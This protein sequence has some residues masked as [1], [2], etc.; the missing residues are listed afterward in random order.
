MSVRIE[1]RCT[2]SETSIWRS[3]AV[4]MRTSDIL[5]ILLAASLPWS[6]SLVAIFAAIFLLSLIPTFDVKAFLLSVKRPASFFPIVLFGLAV[7]GTLWAADITWS[8][9]LNGMNPA[10]K[11]LAI[12]FL[13]YHF[14]KSDRGLWV[15]IA[16]LIS[17]TFVLALSWS[18]FIDLNVVLPS[19]KG[20]GVPVKN[21]IA[22]SQEFTLSAF[23]LLGASTYFFKADRKVLAVLFA[24][25]STLFLANMFFVAT[26]RTALICVPLLLLVFA[27]AHL[28]RRGVLLLVLV[29]FGGLALAWSTS[30]FLRGRVL[31][32]ASEYHRYHDENAV[33]STGQRLE[34]WRKSLKFIQAAP[35]AGHGTGSIRTL[36]E[37]DA[38]GQTGVSAEVIGNPHNQTLNVAVQWG[39]FGVF[40]LYAIWIAH[41]CVFMSRASLAG[42]IGLVAVVQNFISSLFNSHLSDFTEGWLY[43][44]AVGVAG[45]QVFQ[46]RAERKAGEADFFNKRSVR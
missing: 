38:F 39:A 8:A 26:S 2:E 22:Q 32:V 37:R 29:A 44:L 10:V 40:A 43:V 11:L 15:A 28:R 25:S 20:I 33:T 7:V 27:V 23:G 12:P 30:D 17:C 42:W 24:A 36:F 35:F 16:F 31:A 9:R 3:Q 41:L 18:M 45:G 13:I 4:W 6:T 14:E 34:Y 19:D 46:E 5:A 21:S 1:S